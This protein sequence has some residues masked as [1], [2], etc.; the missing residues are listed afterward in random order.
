MKVRSTQL[1]HTNSRIS[2]LSETPLFS[3]LAE[4]YSKKCL[5]VDSLGPTF[6]VSEANVTT[7]ASWDTTGCELKQAGGWNNC[8]RLCPNTSYFLR[9]QV[10][11][12]PIVLTMVF[13]RNG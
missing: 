3:K 13:T 1:L 10:I 7:V 5:S 4:D 8:T 12:N 11:N 6:F 9:K 2:S